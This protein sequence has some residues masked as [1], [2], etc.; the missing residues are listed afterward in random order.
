MIINLDEHEIERR[1]RHIK[2]LVLDCDG[3]LTD[4]RIMLVGEDDE[5]KTFHTRDGHGIVLWHRAGHRTAI[6]SGNSS[7][8]VERRARDLKIE[9]VRQRELN[10]FEA[11]ETLLR[12]AGVEPR[13]VACLGDDVTDIPLMRQAGLGIAVADAVEETKHAAHIVTALNGG[14][15]A[16]RESIEL[17]LKSQGA[18]AE[19]MRRYIF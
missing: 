4:G 8:A 3:V 12:E 17:L 13:E 19:L 18:W 15:G 6:I 2:F 7:S 1:A 11:F 5:T 10:K 9:F 14:Y 16:V